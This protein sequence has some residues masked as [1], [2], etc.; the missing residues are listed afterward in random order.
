VLNTAEQDRFRTIQLAA[1]R[2]TYLGSGMTHPNFLETVGE[3]DPAARSRV[4][5]MAPAFS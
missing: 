2:W 1:L 4:E 3:L 5:T